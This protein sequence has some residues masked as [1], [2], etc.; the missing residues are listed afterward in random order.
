MNAL[1]KAGKDSTATS[2]ISYLPTFPRIL[3]LTIDS[4]QALGHSWQ[5]DIVSS[6]AADTI[7][8]G[9]AESVGEIS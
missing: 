9:T 1:N 5:V 7:V 6:K 2:S 4:A 8:V 3:T